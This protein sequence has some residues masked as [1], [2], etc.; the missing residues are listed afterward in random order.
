MSDT[1]QWKKDTARFNRMFFRA[2]I[3]FLIIGLA[4]GL[5]FNLAKAQET[6]K[7]TKPAVDTSDPFALAQYARACRMTVFERINEAETFSNLVATTGVSD[8]TPEAYLKWTILLG[9]SASWSV[10]YGHSL[11]ALD[12]YPVTETNDGL[13]GATVI[14]PKL[15]G[16]C[17]ESLKGLPTILT[18]WQRAAYSKTWRSVIQKNVAE[19]GKPSSDAAKEA[20]WCGQVFDYAIAQLNRDPLASFGIDRE[21]KASA[22]RLE[23]YRHLF[24]GQRDWWQQ[25]SRKLDPAGSPNALTKQ[26]DRIRQIAFALNNSGL[27][28]QDMLSIKSHFLKQETNI[29]AAKYQALKPAQ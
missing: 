6:T 29:C 14:D 28:P 12:E 5:G 8:A 24:S 13:F 19:A 7:A 25:R 4:I 9:E 22:E 17:A 23:R 27:N 1:D 21:A 20:A 11:M 2:I 18:G 15:T 3:F 26:K 10:L 16:G